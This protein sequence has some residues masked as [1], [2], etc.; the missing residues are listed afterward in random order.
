LAAVADI[1]HSY[2]GGTG[3]GGVFGKVPVVVIVLRLPGR[4]RFGHAP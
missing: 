1:S 3:L 4:W 2:Y